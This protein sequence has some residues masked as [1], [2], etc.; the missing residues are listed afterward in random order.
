MMAEGLRGT[1]LLTRL[2]LIERASVG[3][4]GREASKGD[5]DRRVRA[6]SDLQFHHGCAASAFVLRWLGDGDHVRMFLQILPQSFAQDPHAAAV[7]YS[8]AGQAGEEGAVDELFDFA[9]GLVDGAAD[10][11]DL[12][13]RVR[14]FPVERDGNAPGPCGLYRGLGRAHDDFG[15]IVARDLHLHGADFDLEV[16]VVEAARDPSRAA[17]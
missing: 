8:D 17:H 16:V 6:P 11:V 9:G 14:V 3:F 1:S 4:R 5:A 10:Y 15:Y 2:M 7:H 13:G 12:R